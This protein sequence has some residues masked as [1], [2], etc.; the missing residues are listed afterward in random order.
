MYKHTCGRTVGR[1]HSRG[2]NAPGLCMLTVIITV[3]K[4]AL[5]HELVVWAHCLLSAKW[6]AVGLGGMRPRPAAALVL[7]LHLILIAQ[8]SHGATESECNSMSI[9][10]DNILCYALGVECKCSRP[11]AVYTV[12]GARGGR[13]RKR[14]EHPVVNRPARACKAHAFGARFLTTR[15]V[16]IHRATLSRNAN[17]TRRTQICACRQVMMIPCL[18]PQGSHSETT[19]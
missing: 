8:N 15:F 9:K 18:I 16:V 19:V 6:C 1:K 14:E 13:S 4:A 17:R 12:R 2:S 7:A 10:E 3:Y 5:S 11:C